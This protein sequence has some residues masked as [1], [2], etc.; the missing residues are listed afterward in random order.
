MND[1]QNLREP[2]A[3]AALWADTHAAGFTM[4]SEPLT[5]SLLR[6]LAGSKPGGQLLEIGT[7]TGLSTAW[8]LDGM[9]ARATLTTVDNDDA[10]LDIARRHL[11][12]DPRLSVVC[13]DGD[14]WLDTLAPGTFDLI[15]ADSWPGKYRRLPETLALLRP[16][17]LYVVDDM[18][19]QPNWPEGHELKAA[20]LLET[21]T[22]LPGFST[23]VLSWVTGMVLVSRTD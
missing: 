11:G 7:G 22:T 3:L 20:A 10:V 17:G 15:F 13:A 23:T 4:A 6:T 18:L 9:D 5:G 19:P 12:H 8:L 16:G 21:L 14:A 2:V 1:H